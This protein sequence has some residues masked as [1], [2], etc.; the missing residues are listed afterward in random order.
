MEREQRSIKPRLIEIDIELRALET[1]FF[2]AISMNQSDVAVLLSNRHSALTRE[3][4]FRRSG[5]WETS[6]SNWLKRQ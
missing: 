6:K 5:T 3:S 1:Q 4:I 2:L